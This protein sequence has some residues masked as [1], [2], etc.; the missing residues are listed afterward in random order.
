MV[1]YE[2]FNVLFSPYLHATGKPTAPSNLTYKAEAEGIRFTF[3]TPAEGAT[4]GCPINFFTWRLEGRT[5]KTEKIIHNS[6]LQTFTVKYIE[7]QTEYDVSVFTTNVARLNS[8]ATNQT[9]CL[10]KY[11]F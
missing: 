8:S 5:E 7:K 11:H 4:G 6:T 3:T 9:V 2:W 1:L 10:G